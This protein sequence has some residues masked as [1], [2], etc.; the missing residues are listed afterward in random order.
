MPE[1]HRWRLTPQNGIAV[2]V[3]RENLGI[4][5]KQLAEKI[6]ISQPHLRNL[7]TE[8]RSATREIISRLADALGV[9]LAAITRYPATHEACYQPPPCADEEKP[10]G[11]DT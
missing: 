5:R 8:N 6:G 3:I 2:R 1:R 10:H 11:H 7:E 9:P 4:T